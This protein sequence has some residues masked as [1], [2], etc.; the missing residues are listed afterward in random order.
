MIDLLDLYCYADRHAVEVYWFPMN[1]A[2]SLSMMAPDGSCHIAMDPWYLDTFS[3]EKTKLAHELGHCE[4][5]SF[6]NRYAKLDLRQKHENRADKWAVEHLISADDLDEAVSE[7]YTELWSLADHL[8][9]TEDFMRKAVC[10]HVHGNL[11]ADLY[12]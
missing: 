4:T 7:G 12:F 11:A 8:G 6:Y 9:V 1:T 3:E 10:W 2:E 5:G